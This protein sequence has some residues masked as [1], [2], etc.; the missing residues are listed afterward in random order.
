MSENQPLLSL[1]DVSVSF[2]TAQ[3]VVPPVDSGSLDVDAGETVSIVGAALRD[4]L[5][6]WVRGVR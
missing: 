5:D 3:G 1:T 2:P 6:P 4:L